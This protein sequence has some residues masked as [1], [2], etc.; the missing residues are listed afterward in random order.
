MLSCQDDLGEQAEMLKVE[1]VDVHVLTWPIHCKAKVGVQ[2]QLQL[3]SL[4]VYG[5]MEGGGVVD[6][7]H[8]QGQAIVQCQLQVLYFWASAHPTCNCGRS[9]RWAVRPSGQL[10]RSLFPKRDFGLVI[11]KTSASLKSDKG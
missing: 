5:P 7:T 9:R 1:V 6:H 4:G 8:K 11:P 3:Q 2:L 10:S